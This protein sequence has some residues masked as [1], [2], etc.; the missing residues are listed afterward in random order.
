MADEYNAL[1]RNKTWTLVPPQPGR[2]L[3]DYKWLYKVMH[4]ADSL[5][6]R[7][8]A[9]L[10]VKGFKQRLGIDYDDQFLPHLQPVQKSQHMMVIP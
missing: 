10:V 9:R 5:I 3:I 4:K 1:L 6:D 2:N 7:Y 8:K